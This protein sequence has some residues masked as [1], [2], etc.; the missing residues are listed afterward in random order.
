MPGWRPNDNPSAPIP[1]SLGGR[2]V[3]RST[4]SS[5]SR[6][7]ARPRAGY[8]SAATV[9]LQYLT[10]VHPLPQAKSQVSPGAFVIFSGWQSS[11]INILKGACSA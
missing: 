5:V 1:N 7:K 4:N 9:N 8:P 10:P 11:N 3:A 2:T 6:S